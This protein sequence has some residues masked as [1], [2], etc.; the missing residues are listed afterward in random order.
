MVAGT[1]GHAVKFP[2]RTRLSRALAG[3][4]F[5]ASRSVGQAHEGTIRGFPS[6]WLEQCWW[7]PSSHCAALAEV[8]HP[9]GH[10]H[11]RGRRTDFSYRRDLDRLPVVLLG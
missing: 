2:S 1:T 6:T 11:R 10:H 5:A 3:A 9:D 7:W 4:A 8:C